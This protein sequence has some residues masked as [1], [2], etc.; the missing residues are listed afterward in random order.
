MP[1][2]LIAGAVV[3]AV[4]KGKA[5]KQAANAQSQAAD[6]AIAEQQRQ[7]D[8]TRADQ[9][10]YRDA[11]TAALAK[12]Q[13]P[14]TNFLASPSYNFRRT[15]G[16]RDLGNTWAARGGAFSGNAL[17]ALDT[18][19]SGL[20][21]TEFGNWWNQQ[22][23]LAG[24]GQ[25]AT[26]ATDTAGAQKASNVGNALMYQGNARASGITGAGDALSGLSTDLGAIGYNWNQLKNKSGVNSL[27]QPWWA[28]QNPYRGPWRY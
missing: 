21:S 13:D 19:N 23:G 11:G 18:F 22:A 2:A 26:Q 7:Y 27:A 1:A 17:K 4:V 20:A 24:L 5:A 25:T 14:N 3:G 10:P 28:P 9:A 8:Q 16:T 12:L 15:E 6:S